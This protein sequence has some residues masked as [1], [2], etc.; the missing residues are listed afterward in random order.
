MQRSNVIDLDSDTG[1]TR[2]AGVR[3]DDLLNRAIKEVSVP[4]GDQVLLHEVLE[5][6]E[7]NLVDIVE[8]RAAWRPV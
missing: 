3:I 4:T 8:P 1:V 5:T 6:E 7:D 2:T